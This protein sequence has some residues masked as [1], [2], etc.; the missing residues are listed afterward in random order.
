VGDEVEN[1][2]FADGGHGEDILDVFDM[3]TTAQFDQDD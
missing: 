3:A 2:S 1:F